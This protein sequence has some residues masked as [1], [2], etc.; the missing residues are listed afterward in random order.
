MRASIDETMTCECSCGPADFALSAVSERR[1]DDPSHAADDAVTTAARFDT[2]ER[3]EGKSTWSNRPVWST[4]RFSVSQHEL[5]DLFRR[6]PSSF[7][8]GLR[9]VAHHTRKSQTVPRRVECTPR[10]RVRLEQGKWSERTVR[11]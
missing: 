8:G 1:Y 11:G 10:R 9:D 5:C 7:R 2:R 4:Y 6:P 3:E